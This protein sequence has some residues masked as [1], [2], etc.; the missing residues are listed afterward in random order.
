VSATAAGWIAVGG[1][2][3]S[4][5]LGGLA[6][7]VRAAT[8]AE[9]EQICQ[10][11]GRKALPQSVVA[12]M[13]DQVGHSRALLLARL[14]FDAVTYGAAVWWASSVMGDQQPLLLH[15]AIG[16]GAAVCAL[17]LGSIVVAGSL[18]T[19][20]AEPLVM[21]NATLIRALAILTTPMW[22]IARGVDEVVRRLVGVEKKNDSE[23]AEQD[24]LQVVEEAEATGALPADEASMLE[25]VMRFGD[26][27][28]Q[29]IMTPRTDIEAVALT[30]DLGSL[31]REVRQVRHSRIPVYE[32]SL[33][34]I[35]GLFYVKD[36][37]LWL[38]GEGAR[39]G[40]PF[41]LRSLLRPAYF[42]P[43]TKTVKEL[44]KELME[45]KVHIAIVADEY[46]GTAGIVTIEDIIE[47]VFGDIKDEYESPVT[48]TPD[49]VL[50]ID[51]RKADLDAAARIIDVNEALEPLG[52][53]IPDSDDY[54]TVGGFVVTT[55]G[56][57]P[58]KGERFEHDR[59]MFTIAD[60]MP[61]RVVKVQMEVKS[62]DAPVEEGAGV[63]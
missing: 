9:A 27:T 43:E 12:I 16:L 11:K 2:M 7:S 57:I 46:G 24:I 59:M 18:A 61:T 8:K 62:E 17:W 14:F 13:D 60:A 45:K 23:Q 4:A 33:D 56:R 19:Y 36:L 54:D 55:L 10:R 15:F 39:P 38:G 21:G 20:A 26:L 40:K 29:Q 42:V 51:D 63:G 52:V 5:F 53:K 49:V 35:A 58:T 22:T 37:M 3:G 48:E 50:K 32:E 44:L 1:L 34:Q 30:N 25:S 41:E 28:V 31:I 47:E 6:L